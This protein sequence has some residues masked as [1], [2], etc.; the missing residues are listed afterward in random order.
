MV[1]T[2]AVQSVRRGHLKSTL[3]RNRLRHRSGPPRP[4]LIDR[5]LNVV[6]LGIIHP[7]DKL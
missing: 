1:R 2:A 4:R 3:P 5:G 7:G 6:K